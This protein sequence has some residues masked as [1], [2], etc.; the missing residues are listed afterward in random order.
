MKLW[1]DL[2][3]RGL[4]KQ[5]TD[6]KLG[7]LVNG[8]EP[9]TLYCGFDPTADTLHVG[10]LLPLLVLRRF[11]Q[12][13]HKPIAV[14]GGATGMIGDPSGKSAERSL[15]DEAQLQRNVIG[16][17]KVTERFLDLPKGAQVA[18]NA[19]WFKGVSYL[20][21]LRDVGKHFTVNHMMAKESVRARLE[22]RE[23][24]IS[25]TEFS[26]MLLQ[27]YDF[28]VLN[29]KQ[30]CTLQIGG[31]D[32]W[33]NITAGIELNRRMRSAHGESP[34]EIYGMTMPLVMKSDGTKFGKTESGTVWLTADRTS[35][36][37]FYQFFIQ[38]ADS[39]VVTYLKYFT[40]LS[41]EEISRLE[42]SVREAPEKREAQQALARELTVLVHGQAEYERV[43]QA[44]KALF[45]GD[46][47]S[48]DEKTLRE[49]TREAPTT[50][51]A[52]GDLNAGIKLV[53]LL[54]ETGLCASKG[55][56]RKD[57][58]G[59]GIY[60]NGDRVSEV[61]RSLSAV[62]LLCGKF[63]LLRKGKKQQHVVE[64]Q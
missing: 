23:H 57:I 13:G 46:L 56:A 28:Y 64:F 2:Q 8:A 19:D 48:M 41:H 4:V 26:Y 9:L 3:W 63:I 10:S 16:I 49:T 42:K 7:A 51:K 55:M 47:K 45:Q 37:E 11:Q 34:S 53:D 15:L 59:G 17:R 58:Q 29:R 43:T 22:D 39:D 32:Q 27:A 25:Y 40:F 36:Y 50:Q 44:S 35:P 5:A 38:T 24:G 1:E 33:G 31:S 54:A 52:R 12:A 14:V 60:V 61:E 18:N 21:F 62:D 30:K 20:S 6:E